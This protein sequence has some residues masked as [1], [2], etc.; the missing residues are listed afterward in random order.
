MQIQLMVYIWRYPRA[1]SY[2]HN[3]FLISGSRILA[4]ALY[5]MFLVV[6]IIM[7]Q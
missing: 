6:P 7:Q 4:R 2:L 5:G 3:S 1:V